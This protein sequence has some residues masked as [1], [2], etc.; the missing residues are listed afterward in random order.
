MRHPYPDAAPMAAGFVISS[1]L[2]ATIRTPHPSSGDLNTA[3]VQMGCNTPDQ[4]CRL[5]ADPLDTR[6]IP[7]DETLECRLSQTWGFTA[8]LGGAA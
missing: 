2:E 5:R 8:E 4:P 6:S 1:K 7:R 3:S